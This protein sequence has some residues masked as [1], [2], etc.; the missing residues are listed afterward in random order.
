[1]T[2]LGKLF[3]TTA[4]K[5]SPAF[6]TAGTSR[7]ANPFSSLKAEV[8]TQMPRLSEISATAVKPGEAASMRSP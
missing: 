5:L 7:R 2:A 4:F 3:R 8:A 6:G 1:M